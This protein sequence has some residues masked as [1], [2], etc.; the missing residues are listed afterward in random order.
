LPF[1]KVRIVNYMQPEGDHDIE[2]RNQCTT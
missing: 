2:H 1:P